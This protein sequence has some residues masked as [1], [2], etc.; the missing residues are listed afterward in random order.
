MHLLHGVFLFAVNEG[1]FPERKGIVLSCWP[2]SINWT[3][4]VHKTFL[5]KQA[6]AANI[7]LNFIEKSMIEDRD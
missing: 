6:T 4:K 3:I 7:V 5:Y 1:Q 2:A